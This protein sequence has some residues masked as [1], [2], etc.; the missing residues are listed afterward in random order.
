MLRWAG[1]EGSRCLKEVVTTQ[2]RQED[3]DSS[4]VHQWGNCTFL[5]SWPLEP[6]ALGYGEEGLWDGVSEEKHIRST[7]ELG[8]CGQSRLGRP[9]RLWRWFWRTEKRYKTR[10]GTNKGIESG[11]IWHVEE[12]VLCLLCGGGAQGI[13]VVEGGGGAGRK[14]GLHPGG[15]GASMMSCWQ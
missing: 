8:R 9:T 10:D 5:G 2:W 14:G 12:T 6:T 1:R 13:W 3:K 15:R 7:P 11:G 4:L